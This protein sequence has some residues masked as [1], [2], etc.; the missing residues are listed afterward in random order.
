[1][2]DYKMLWAYADN[3]KTINLK[4]KSFYEFIYI[5]KT[6]DPKNYQHHLEPQ[7]NEI[8]FEK[9]DYIININN[10]NNFLKSIIPNYINI[11]KKNIVDRYDYKCSTIHYKPKDYN[12]VCPY[13]QNLYNFELEQIVR[14]YIYKK[15]YEQ[16]F[17]KIPF[18]CELD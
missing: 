10:A 13:R 4:D 6:L 11:S 1:M 12:T 16:L 18:K 5:L 2:N 14:N 17:E 15:D 8:I 9:T 3:N 7:T